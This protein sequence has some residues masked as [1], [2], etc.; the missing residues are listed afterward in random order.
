MD[1]LF[2]YYKNALTNGLCQE[3]KG[4]WQSAHGDKKKLV[5]LVLQQQALPHF[6]TYCNNG[7]GLSKEYLLENFNDYINGNYVAIDVDG[8]KGNYK[9]QLYVGVKGICDASNDV[10]CFMWSNVPLVE[11]QTCK[12]TKIYCGCNSILHISCGGY[13]N[14][15]IM[16]FDNSQVVLDDVDEDSTIVIYK[17]S[18]KCNVEHGKFCFGKVK[19]F[20][21]TLRL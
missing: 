7:Q 10:S 8:V 12:A 14:I 6:I 9:T 21:K 3:Y 16:L 5:D 15:T 4:Y 13:N 20:T 18:N 2:K 11:I 1:D 17:Y 19:E